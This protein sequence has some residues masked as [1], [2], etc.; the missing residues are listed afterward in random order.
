MLNPIEA[1]ES[2]KD[3]F[4]DYITTSFDISD[5]DYANQLKVELDKHGAIAKGPYL[6]IGGSYET[7]KSLRQLISD[8]KASPLFEEMEPI[9]E[10]DRELK[11]DR[12]LYLH[13]MTAL[14]KANAHKNFVVT[15]GTGSGKTECFLIPIIDSL[16]R[17]IEVGTLTNAVRA[18]IIY[19]M[20]ALANDQMKR[21]R[22][23]LKNYPKIRFGLYNGNTEYS[24]T[25]AVQ[26]YH[27]TYHDEQ[28]NPLEP[29]PNE[30]LSREEMQAVPPHILITNYSMLEYMMLRPKD[31]AVFSGAQLRYIILDEAHIYKGATGMETSLLMRRLRAR[32]SAPENVQY[33]LTSATLG[34][35]NGDND[36]IAF[37]QRLSG[38]S[39]NAEDI[40][41]SNE[42]N[43]EIKDRIDYPMRMFTELAHPTE[44]ISGILEKYNADFVPNA[45]NE[46]QLFE[47]C[48][49]SRLFEA[50]RNVATQPMTI[51]ELQNSLSKLVHVDHINQ[52]VD[53]ISV[54]AQAEKNKTSLIKA[55]YHFFV[56]TLEGA[57]ITLNSPKKL[58]L[59]RKDHT[60]DIANPQEVFECA[61]CGDCGRMAIVGKIRGDKLV[62]SV[63]NTID[64]PLGYFMI[65]ESSEASL[66]D[67]DDDE[68]VSAE[69]GTTENDFVVCPWCGAIAHESDA[70][71][72]AP[73]EHDPKDYV[74]VSK[75]RISDKG[76]PK[77]PACGFGHLRHFYLGNDAAT[78]V[79][80]TALFEQLPTEET[81]VEEQSLSI[82]NGIFN[83]RK[84]SQVKKKLKTRQF[85]CF[86][87]S[88]SEAAFFPVYMEKSYEEFLRRRGIWHVADKFREDRRTTV[89]MKEFVDVLTRYFEENHTFVEWDTPENR[90]NDTL[91]SDSKRNAWI[92]I[93]N[94]MYNARRSTSLP[95]MG[96]LAFEYVNNTEVAESFADFYNLEVS[97]ARALLELLVLDGVYSGAVNAGSEYT[98]NDAEREYIF[99]AAKPK[100]MKEMKLAEDAKHSWIMGWEGRK[101][102]NGNYFPNGRLIRITRAIGISE[103]KANDLL[104]GFW[105][106][107]FAPESDEFVL[108]ACD[109]KVKIS[110]DP[111]LKFYRCSK[112]GKITCHNIRNQCSSVKCN[113]VLIP[114]EPMDGLTNNHY[115]NL[116]RSTQMKPLYI[117]EHTAQLAKNQQTKY[118]QAFVNKQIHALSCSTTFEMG[119]DVGSLETVYM[120]DV[121]PSPAN[122]VQRAGR[123][124]RALHSTAFILTYCKLSSHDFTFYKNPVDMISGKIKAPVFEIEN[125]KIIYR[126][127]FAV[128]IGSFFSENEDVYDGDNQTVLLNEDG[129]ERLKDYLGQHPESLKELLEK[130][131]PTAVH[132]RMDIS[133]WLWT[134]KLIGKEGVLEIAVQDFRNTVSLF[135]KLIKDCRKLHDDEGAGD[136]SRKLKSFRCSKE[137]NYGRKSLIDFLVRNNVLPKYGFPVDT[138]ELF[139]DTST[140][141]KAGS[142]QLARDLQIAIAEYAPGSEVVADGKMYTSRYIRKV[143]SKSINI[144]WEIG[145][146]CEHCPRC[147]EPTF[148]KETIPPEG[149]ECVS[150]HNIIRKTYWRETLEPRRGFYAEHD[151]KPVP[152]RKPDHD[153]KTDDY[154]VGDPHSNVIKKLQFQCVGQEV[155]LESTSN[156]SLVVI[157]QTE[158]H[159]CPVCGYASEDAIPQPHY[160]AYGY[161]C[162]NKEGKEKLYQLSHDFKTDVAKIT[163][164]THEAKQLQVML[165]VLYALLEGISRELG[166]ERTDIKGCL[167][168]VTWN[169]DLIYS[170]ILYDGVAGGA[171]H[172]RRIVTNDGESLRKV[173]TSA[174]NLTENCD[175]DTSC[176]K[177]LRNYY[178]QKIHD[179]L[180]RNLA[181]QFLNKWTAPF[182][183][184]EDT[185]EET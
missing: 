14:I 182:V 185:S 85:L 7:G 132:K 25:K 180:D 104:K 21:M 92:G 139:P 1:S 51:W 168:K 126:H 63:K 122:Y 36:I 127:V 124:G 102:S 129:Y 5:K 111:S 97:Q 42:K 167:H 125:E 170:V 6:D 54:C 101:R 98:L 55:R 134:E 49:H 29:Q 80:G 72:E 19:P 95:A 77:C 115:A 156:D 84:L 38:V 93:L 165:S 162:S 145:H 89:S 171:G 82:E 91:H 71:Y 183:P 24:K 164:C 118:Q 78:A 157:G 96:I 142:L 90:I 154:Y 138:V 86:S 31:D 33:I 79:L 151:P 4:I 177:C 179:Q 140:I 68:E 116:Y 110:G 160:N 23:L 146:Y 148:T 172:V 112:C 11:L 67:E 103:D 119:V 184:L 133:N 106:N 131:I 83:R 169:N 44:K 152:M 13:Q 108:D 65:K 114:Y 81:Y 3:S 59:Q 128:A 22:A 15:T 174:I 10:K 45:N 28:G 40:V 173:I 61:V 66:Q 100:V 143:Q 75:I 34:G 117:K 150:C 73:C 175:C 158:Y 137:D 178:N 99:F 32:I 37:A 159:V 27:K 9:D 48:L 94:E 120:R 88:R 76:L 8:G 155:H 166:I 62:Q 56:R 39:F 123:A 2:I 136:Y 149:R 161:H 53:F 18:I 43:P 16:L 47:L 52:L 41:R 30:I 46:E 163:F 58:F 64:G 147:K 109:F 181:A 113:G 107:V 50:L 26:E 153:F 12:P 17:E 60:E 130:S 87:D 105:T 176:Y 57:F 74:K 141:G 135:E 20:N 144:S 35:R 69:N 121:P 70:K